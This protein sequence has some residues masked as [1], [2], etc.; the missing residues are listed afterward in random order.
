MAERRCRM[1]EPISMRRTIP[2]KPQVANESKARKTLP[3][4]ASVLVA[5]I[6]AA[7]TLFAAAQP[8]TQAPA[9]STVTHKASHPHK[10][11]SAAHPPAP[12]VQAAPTP[13]APPAPVLPKWPAN[14]HPVEATIVWDS[15]GLRIEASN[16]SLGQILKDVATVTGSK[17]EGLGSD[18]RIF[19]SFGPGKARDVLSQLLDG[20]G[21]NVLMIGDQGQ[22]TPREVVLS[23][24]RKGDAPQVSYDQTASNGENTDNDEQP[25]PQPQPQPPP[26]PVPPNIRN[27]FEPGAP[28]RTPQQIMQEMQQRQQQIEQMQQQANPP[29]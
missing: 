29:Q 24:Q 15:N 5:S 9:A 6:L 18:Q 27:G 13:A 16:S 14:D 25:V 8:T 19:G 23:A 4:R 7:G 3:V 28:P 1:G 2:E 21:Y 22:G 26:Q 17:V 12:S 20:S 11:P 10:R